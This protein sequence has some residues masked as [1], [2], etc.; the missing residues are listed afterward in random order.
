M[1]GVQQV[2]D[3]GGALI[4][5]E[6][7][8]SFPDLAVRYSGSLVLAEV[9]HPGLNHEGLEVAACR[10]DVLVE[11]PA[12]GPVPPTNASE[13]EHGRR[14]LDGAPR[15]NPVFDGDKHGPAL[16]VRLVNHHWSGS[17]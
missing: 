14:E 9:L 7:A 13:L 11:S 12:H 4:E 15:I 3:G 17:R 2:R 6:G 10:S 16:H 1:V 5:V 8:H